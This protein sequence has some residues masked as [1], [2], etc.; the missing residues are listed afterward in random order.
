[1]HFMHMV[2]A[3][4]CVRG[5]LHGCGPRPN[6]TL[7]DDAFV[8]NSTLG[9]ATSLRCKDDMAQ[10]LASIVVGCVVYGW[11]CSACRAASLVFKCTHRTYS[12]LL[13]T[14]VSS[15][16]FAEF[17]ACKRCGIAAGCMLYAHGM[18]IL[19]TR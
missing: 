13:L 9:A 2:C 16:E 11:P 18:Y 6:A 15:M 1:M 7:L 12:V 14:H 17:L 3:L 8:A 4:R 10:S 5:S 19:R